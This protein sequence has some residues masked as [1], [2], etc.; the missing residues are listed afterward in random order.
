MF[1]DYESG[2]KKYIDDNEKRIVRNNNLNSKVEI[3]ETMVIK[4]VQKD[5]YMYSSKITLKYIG[6]YMQEI[7]QNREK[8][9]V[10]LQMFLV[11]KTISN[12]K[13]DFTGEKTTVM[14]LLRIKINDLDFKK[15]SKIY[16][17]EI[18]HFF[19]VNHIRF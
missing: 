12:M 3:T 7:F 2:I 5:S 11:G 8:Q 16:L 19:K 4:E 1:S 14:D 10:M 18:R 6:D 13:Y 17:C 9:R 15:K